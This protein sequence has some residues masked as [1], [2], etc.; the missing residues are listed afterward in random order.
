MESPTGEELAEA[1]GMYA[2]VK[3]ER[4]ELKAKLTR[5]PAR[6][7]E[8]EAEVAR[9]R[10]QAVD[11]TSFRL[12]DEHGDAYLAEHDGTYTHP[13]EYGEG[14]RVWY[15]DEARPEGARAL[16]TLTLRSVPPAPRLA[17]DQAQV[18]ELHYVTSPEL[19]AVADELDV[20]N[21]ATA[22]TTGHR[23][24]VTIRCS[25][26]LAHLLRSR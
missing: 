4:D 18:G 24:T 1:L 6:I 21:S 5:G 22:P 17:P 13:A 10:G 14:N 26:R 12:Y 3:A 16:Y 20:L 19:R 23:W 25:D 2:R 7:Q 9:L 11:A 15:E 8:L